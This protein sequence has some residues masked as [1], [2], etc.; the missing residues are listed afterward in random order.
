MAGQ[1]DAWSCTGRRTCRGRR[2]SRART[3]VVNPSPRCTRWSP[4]VRYLYRRIVK[5]KAV[6]RCGCT[7][8]RSAIAKRRAF[9]AHACFW[10]FSA[11]APGMVTIDCACARSV[12]VATSWHCNAPQR[13]RRSTF[14]TPHARSASADHISCLSHTLCFL[15]S[16]ALLGP[17]KART[18][19][20]CFACN[21]RSVTSWCADRWILL[22]RNQCLSPSLA[23][24]R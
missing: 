16:V 23:V 10:R 24:R 4:T 6:H 12:K 15:F 3:R 5:L 11:K 19:F 7:P 1:A 20:F 22:L 9:L 17:Q 8:A 18:Y 13:C 2:P 21:C 14:V